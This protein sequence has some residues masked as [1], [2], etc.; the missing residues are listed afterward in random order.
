MAFHEVSFKKTLFTLL[1]LFSGCSII[2]QVTSKDTSRYVPEQYDNGLEYNLII[3]SSKGLDTEV[4]RLILRGAGVDFVSDDGVTPLIYAVSNKRSK[5][6]DVLLSYGADPNNKT[7]DG[8]T[9]LMVILKEFVNIGDIELTSVTA[10]VEDECLNIAESLLRYGADIDYQDNYG[11]TALNYAAIYGSFRFADL[12]IYYRADI[13]RKAYDGTT[14]LMA[15]V[16]AGNAAVADLLV[17]NGA[18]MEA[19]DNEG[20][21]A[22]LI[23]AQNGDTL[24]LDYLMKKGVDIYEK[25]T[26]GWDALSLSIRY[27]HMDA[28]ALLIRSGE[29]FRETGRGSLHYYNVAV[30]FKRKEMFQLLEKNDFPDHYKTQISQVELSISSK[31]THTDVYTGMNF[32]FREPRKS[33]GLVTGFDTKLWHTRVLMKESDSRFYQY[34]D[35]SSIVYAGIFKDIQ[36]TDNAFKSNVILSGSLS[37]GY[38]FG[39]M[40]LGTE[41]SPESGFRI[42]PSVSLKIVKKNFGAF[43]GVEYM[44]TDFYRVW[45]LWAR[46]GISYNFDLKHSKTPVK[47]IKWY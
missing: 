11:A 46:A 38:F 41:A 40:Y 33:I 30:K 31:L 32:L 2:A 24:L 27:N 37:A 47:T 3:A 5:A 10:S 4:E 8:T 36:L 34:M 29:K 43:T 23:A 19:R 1:I 18:N 45:P 21:T 44:N 15:A 42:I 26:N 9:P 25:D 16:W 35:K 6:V 14:P 39:N 28:A 22:F 13:D 17:Q 7:W 20:F 12:L